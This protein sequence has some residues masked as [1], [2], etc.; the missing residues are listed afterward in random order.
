MVTIYT[1]IRREG[2]ALQ[3][4]WYLDKMFLCYAMLWFKR[5][6]SIQLWA[7]SALN[8]RLITLPHSLSIFLSHHSLLP[9]IPFLH[10]SPLPMYSNL[11]L[12]SSLSH[13]VSL[14]LFF[15]PLAL[16]LSLPRPP[17]PLWNQYQQQQVASEDLWGWAWCGMIFSVQ[18]RFLWHGFG[19]AEVLQCGRRASWLAESLGC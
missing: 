11:A 15:S 5:P 16:S 8:H 4:I 10:P 1:S 9:C 14:P 7:M 2:L 18:S 19:W 17:S 3:A 12:Y 6:Y 13:Y